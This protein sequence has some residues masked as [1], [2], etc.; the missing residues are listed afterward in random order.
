[1]LTPGLVLL[2]CLIV[3]LSLATLVGHRSGGWGAIVLGAAGLLYSVATYPQHLLLVTFPLSVVLML[4]G[5]ISV[6]V[7]RL[8]AR[9]GSPKP[10]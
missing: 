4:T 10:N 5:C 3:V 8:R 9:R 1:M 7:P 6:A 2:A